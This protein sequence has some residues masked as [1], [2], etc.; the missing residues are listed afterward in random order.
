MRLVLLFYS[1]KPSNLFRCGIQQ[2]QNHVF[3]RFLEDPLIS[4]STIKDDDHLA[5]YKI[6]KSVKKT[7]VLRLIHRRQERYVLF[8]L[9]FIS[10]NCCKHMP[11]LVQNGI[12]MY[13]F[14]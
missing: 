8:S 1:Y 2:V 11:L 9:N 3:Q 4:L 14:H 13:Y 7:L 6:P 10:S 12:A 5:A